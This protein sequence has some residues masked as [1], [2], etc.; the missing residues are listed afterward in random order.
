MCF[1]VCVTERYNVRRES[2]KIKCRSSGRKNSGE[3]CGV[4]YSQKSEALNLQ[5]P[6][7][8]VNVYC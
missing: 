7:R 8:T 1:Y 5:C 2:L 4:W 3:V 6:V